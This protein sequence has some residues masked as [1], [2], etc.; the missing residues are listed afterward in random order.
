MMIPQSIQTEDESPQ[1][2]EKAT[3]KDY[4]LNHEL[5]ARRW[6]KKQGMY[7]APLAPLEATFFHHMMCVARMPRGR[8]EGQGSQQALFEMSIPSENL[9]KDLCRSI[10]AEYMGAAKYTVVTKRQKNVVKWKPSGTTS[11]WWISDATKMYDQL[12]LQRS[13]GDELPPALVSTRAP[14]AD[15]R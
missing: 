13:A 3:Q 12:A 14:R 9:A 6:L 4:D 2:Y 15:W 8:V 1:L 7:F 10:G 11:S 5:I